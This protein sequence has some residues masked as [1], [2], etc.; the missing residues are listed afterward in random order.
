MDGS[1]KQPPCEENRD[2]QVERLAH[3]WLAGGSA[4][5]VDEKFPHRRRNPQLTALSLQPPA[6]ATPGSVFS[7]LVLL[8]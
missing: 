3:K 6:W 5:A 2:R 1:V 4:L 8:M 7:G